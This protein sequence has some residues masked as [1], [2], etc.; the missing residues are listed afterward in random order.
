MK[1]LIVMLMVVAFVATAAVAMAQDKGPAVIKLTNKGTVTFNHTAH[2]AAATCDDCHK[3]TANHPADTAKCSSCH[4]KS[5]SKAD[6]KA[7]KK[8][9]H[10]NCIDCHKA[11]NK[12]NGDKKA[13]TGCKKCHVK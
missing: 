2:Q 1:K 7:Y 6:K 10:K 5:D 11:A 4:R 13:P 3:S 8:A 9:M 12:K